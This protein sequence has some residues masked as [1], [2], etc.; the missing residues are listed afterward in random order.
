MTAGRPHWAKAA[1]AAGAGPCPA[2]GAEDWRAIRPGWL[3]GL[4]Q[5]LSQ[6]GAWRPVHAVCGQCGTAAGW[7]TALYRGRLPIRWW[8]A[9]VRVPWALWQA[10]RWSRTAIPSPAVYLTAA[11]A[12]GALGVLVQLTVGWPWWL[13]CVLA[14][15]AVWLLFAATALAGPGAR[16][17]VATRVLGAV[18]PG[19]AAARRERQEAERV[20]AA[21]FLLYGLPPVWPGLRHLAGT[22][23]SHARGQRRPAVTEVALGHGDPL[24]GEPTL[25]VAVRPAAPVP[26]Q[27]RWEPER[28]SDSDWRRHA[29]LVDDRPVEFEWLAE[30]RGWVARGET[31]DVLVTI[32]A[33]DFP[34]DTVELVR[35]ADVQRYIEGARQLRAAVA[36]R[37][38]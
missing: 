8:T 4:G 6:G 22:G 26:G 15:I 20:R 24:T 27:T 29:V 14:V 16:A 35:I 19:R 30:G 5:W 1:L 32:E 25:T 7:Q 9:P 3:A 2:C 12:G 10:I 31:E 34:I 33:R 18:S 17:E 23:W 11:A 38:P 28:R 36:H 37:H 13:P 21:P